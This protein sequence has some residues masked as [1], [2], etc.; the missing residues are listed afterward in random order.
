MASL[1]AYIAIKNKGKAG[2]TGSGQTGGSQVAKNKQLSDF[3]KLSAQE[4][5]NLI[6]EKIKQAGK[7]PKDKAYLES[8]LNNKK[9]NKERT[10]KY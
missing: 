10:S 1:I 6:E 2:G 5:A 9:W 3:D 8:L 7:N 4:I